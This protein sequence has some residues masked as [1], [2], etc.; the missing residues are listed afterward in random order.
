[1]APAP[2][3]RSR[4]EEAED[5]EDDANE[6]EDEDDE[7]KDD[8]EEEAAPASPA[9]SVFLLKNAN[10]SAAL[11]IVSAVVW[12]GA[13]SALMAGMFWSR[14]AAPSWPVLQQCKHVQVELQM[15]PAW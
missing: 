15:T 2:A 12:P 1:M 7:D 11:K 4:P 5:E 3:P 10:S 14:I 13:G 6:D 9:P 8:D